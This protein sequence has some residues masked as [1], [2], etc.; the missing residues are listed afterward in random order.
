MPGKAEEQ[1]SMAAG[2]TASEVRKGREMGHEG[3]AGAQLHFLLLR[4][5]GASAPAMVQPT[6]RVGPSTPLI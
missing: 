3:D 5:S 2:Y 4:Q 1:K 6:F